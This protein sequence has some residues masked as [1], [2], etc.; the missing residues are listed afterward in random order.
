MHEEGFQWLTENHRIEVNKDE[1]RRVVA[2]GG[3]LARACVGGRERG[4][5]RAWPGGVACAR[6]IGDADCGAIISAVPALSTLSYPERGAA[7][8]IC[9]DGVWD[10]LPP[11]AISRAAAG[12]G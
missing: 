9:S 8:V 6:S 1:Q 12:F 4:P 11:D 10:T 7:L 5:L 2:C 3:T